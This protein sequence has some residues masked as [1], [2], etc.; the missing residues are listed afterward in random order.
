MLGGILPLTLK[1]TGDCSKA[2]KR[3]TRDCIAG[4]KDGTSVGETTLPMRNITPAIVR[5]CPRLSHNR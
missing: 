3:I 4:G 2:H 1:D 5:I